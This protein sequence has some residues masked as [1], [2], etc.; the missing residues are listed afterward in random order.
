MQD[1]RAYLKVKIKSLAEEA[2]IIRKE[3]RASQG[4]KREGLHNHRVG[5]VRR[6]ARHSLLAY[7]FIRGKKYRDIEPT[8]RTSPYR[9]EVAKMVVKYGLQDYG[10]KIWNRAEKEAAKK[11]LLARLDAWWSA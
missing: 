2:K 4:D 11:E 10:W 1:Q 9:G 7:G 5:V 3:E 8:A 6:A